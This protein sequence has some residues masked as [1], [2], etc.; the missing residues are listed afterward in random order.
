[1]T[2][3]KVIINLMTFSRFFYCYFDIY[4][5]ITYFK[6]SFTFSTDSIPSFAQYS[7]IPSSTLI[8]IEGSTKVPVPIC[9]AEAPA[10]RYCN[11]SSAVIMPPM[12]MTGIATL[13]LTFQVM[14]T[15][16]GRTAGPL[17]WDR[18]AINA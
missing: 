1:L 4:A 12:P 5:G 3:Y 18:D 14:A 6:N 13:R 8:G 7:L 9:M 10:R 17:V 16:T 15:P 11:A 2:G